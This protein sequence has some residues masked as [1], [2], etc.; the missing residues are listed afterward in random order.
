LVAVAGL[1]TYKG[2]DYKLMPMENEPIGLLIRY[3][4]GGEP[5]SYTSELIRKVDP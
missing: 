4:V 3:G 5:V 1:V 2:A